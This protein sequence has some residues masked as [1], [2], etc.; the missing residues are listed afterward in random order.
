MEAFSSSKTQPPIVEKPPGEAATNKPPQNLVTCVHRAKIA[1]EENN[2]CTF[3]I[4]LSTWQ[5]WARKGV[6]SFKVDEKRI[7]VFWDF[8]IKSKSKASLVDSRLLYKKEN[9]VGK[10]CFGARSLLGNGK[11]EHDIHIETSFSVNYDPQMW[12]AIDQTVVVQVMNLHWRF[13]G[14]ETVIV[15]DMPVQIFWDVYDWL[16]NGSGSGS[17]QGMFIFR[18]GGGERDSDDNGGAIYYDECSKDFCHLVYAWKRK[19]GAWHV[20]DCLLG[21]R[22]FLLQGVQKSKFKEKLYVELMAGFVNDNKISQGLINDFL[23]A[24]TFSRS[25]WSSSSWGPRRIKQALFEKGVSKV[26]A[27]KAIQ[28]V[29]E[30]RESGE[31]QESSRLGM[32]KHSIDHLI[33]QASKQWLRGRDGPPDK[34]KSRIIRW[35]QY[36][37]FNW[38]VIS[39]VLK[40]LESEYSP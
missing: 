22:S 31:D 20:C 8:R 3:K 24:E 5:F 26:D 2:C 30:D 7:D 18:Q 19:S 25:R 17:G 27:E 32:S 34:Q 36:R 13:R 15:D 29:F 35:L 33:V 37:G 39:F 1:V 28:L 11:K 16:F 10:K 21:L 6:K 38:G 4:D 14:N 23:Y 40:K 9:V 12:I